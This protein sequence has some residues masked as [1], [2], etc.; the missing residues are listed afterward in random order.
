MNVKDDPPPSFTD[1]IAWRKAIETGSFR[2]FKPEVLVCA[3]QEITDRFIREALASRLSEKMMA[4]LRARVGRN[5][6]NQGWDIIER[7]HTELL[8]SLFDRSSA[9]GKAM[10]SAFFMIVNYRIKSAIATE[11]KHSRIPNTSSK[12]VGECGKY[13]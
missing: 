5:H 6:P 13:K 2:M 10:R 4:L 9:D 3:L 12:A 7:V 8:T 11:L 1:L